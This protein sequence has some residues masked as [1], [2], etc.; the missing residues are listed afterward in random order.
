MRFNKVQLPVQDCHNK[1]NSQY[2]G[3]ILQTLKSNGFNHFR[4]D[5]IELDSDTP[6]DELIEAHR[7]QIDALMLE[8]DYKNIEVIRIKNYSS[9]TG[10]YVY[11]PVRDLYETRLI[12]HGQCSLFVRI[13]GKTFEFQCKQ[14]DVIRLPADLMY[15][16]EVGLHKCRYIHLFMTEDGWDMPSDMQKHPFYIATTPGRIAS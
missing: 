10:P 16:L 11:K 1:N 2:I 3:D 9:D 6:D 4:F 7:E 5:L 14:G 8:D 12:T 13:N 15:W